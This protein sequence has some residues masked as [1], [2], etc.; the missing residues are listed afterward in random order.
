M[1]PLSKRFES[2]GPFTDAADVRAVLTAEI[3]PVV[4]SVDRMLDELRSA[5]DG[6]R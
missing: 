1:A 6:R 3:A 4:E 5:G 2:Q